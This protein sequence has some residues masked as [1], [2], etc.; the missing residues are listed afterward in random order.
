MKTIFVLLLIV[1]LCSVLQTQEPVSF[2]SQA[3]GGIISDDLD[4]VYDPIELR[5]VE[6]I[7]LYTNLSNLTSGQEQLM[8]NYS[9]NEFLAGISI[10]NPFVKNL[11]TSALVRY[12]NEHNSMPVM[13]DQN[14]D[15]IID[16][17][18]EGE[19]RD[20]Y[21]AFLDTDFNGL[22][23]FR[24]QIDQKKRNFNLQRSHSVVLNN[25]LLIDETTL[26]LQLSF[27]GG[28]NENTVASSFIGSG[29]NGLGQTS[30]GDPEFAL[31]YDTYVLEDGLHNYNQ[32]ESGKYLNWDESSYISLLFSGMRP[33]T[34]GSLENAEIRA[35]LSYTRNNNKN[36]FND[37]YTGKAQNFLPDTVEYL[38]TYSEW[39]TADHMNESK[40]SVWGIGLGLKQVFN[41]AEERKNDGFWSVNI[42]M[43][44][45]SNDYSM[46]NKNS[47]SSL[48]AYN[49]GIDTL[50]QD[51]NFEISR[52]QQTS[53]AGDESLMDLYASFRLNIPLQDRVYFGTG[54][55]LDFS[56][57]KRTTDWIQNRNYLETY[58]ILDSLNAMD[59]TR[60]GK[61]N[62]LA[63]RTYE[64][65]LYTVSVPVGVEYKFSENK[66]W[67]IR[68]GSIFE[69]WKFIVND[70][71]QIK[72]SE[73][74]TVVTTYGNGTENVTVEN[75]ISNS[76]SNHT[77]DSRSV[78]TFVYGLGYMPT[79]N[80]QI[81]LL[82]FLGST[83]DNQI[84]DANFFRS[85]RLSF[86]LKL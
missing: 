30:S 67:S 38:D 1:I 61:V 81:D 84:L 20:I 49:D 21:N 79:D 19:Y 4:L 58:D 78:T 2:R 75:N 37:R 48:D 34:L 24:R 65:A 76:T 27:G 31:Q 60:V 85:L 83:D 32:T 55:F 22:Y 64:T 23:D 86:S 72:K 5:F 66:K 8:N 17:D 39:E 18:E 54:I 80:L 73:P 13:I 35:D 15:G 10:G 68:F 11:W 69:Y 57:T 50:L 42:G 26:G 63:D 3:L 45:G 43:N 51:Q 46:S 74:Y 47:F 41:K 29:T 12:K 40:G 82:G 36:N 14:L 52:V 6:G 9:D 56:K 44:I 28:R 71:S 62:Y 16:L 7:H 53:D 25:S 33:M 77:K 70:K 59:Y